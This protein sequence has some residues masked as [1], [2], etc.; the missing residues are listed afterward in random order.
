MTT[1]KRG[2]LKA[3]INLPLGAIKPLAILTVSGIDYQDNAQVPSA[4]QYWGDISTDGCVLLDRIV[5]GVYRL[6]IY[7][8]G[9][10]GDYIM[11]NVIIEE[12]KLTTKNI[13]WNPET[14]GIELWRIGTPDK[15]S[16]EFRSGNQPDLTHPLHLPQYRIYWAQ[17]SSDFL[18]NFPHGVNFTVGQ[19]DV[20]TALNVVHWSTYGGSGN[21]VG[22]LVIFV[23]KKASDALLSFD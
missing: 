16:G 18:T 12:G 11:D 13:E 3:V 5:P 14:N 2:T 22:S 10:F 8:E 17:A 4:Y 1:K 15:S 19:D 7:A 21:T 9:I 20:S 6:T 23:E